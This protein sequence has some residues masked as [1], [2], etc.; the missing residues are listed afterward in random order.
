MRSTTWP[1]LGSERRAWTTPPGAV[2]LTRRER[3]DASQP[4]YEAALVPEIA[5][6]SPTLPTDV[7]AEAEDAVAEMARFDAGMGHEV[8]P[9]APVLL[10][11]E[12]IASSDIEH[13]TSSARNIALAEAT[14][15]GG[16]D[17]A[18]LVARNVRAMLR[19][20][21]ATTSPDV[22]GVLDLHAE[23]MRADP[24]HVAG[25]FR[26]EQVWIGGHSST[27]VGAHFVPPHHDRVAA[28]MDDL[29]SFVRRPDLPRLTQ[30]AV[31]HAQFETIHPFSD[32][33][34]RTGR[35]LMHVMLRDN[36]LV[37]HGV[38]P[39]SA[40]LLTDTAAYH[41]ALDAYRDGDP[42]TIVRLLTSSSLRAVA[43]ATRLVTEVRGIRQSW[44]ERVR[45]RRGTWTWLVVDLLLR[46]P[47]LTARTLKAELG[48]SPTHAPRV[49]EPLLQAGVVRRATH[50]ASRSTYWWSPEI[51][52]AVDDFAVRAGRR[53]L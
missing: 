17:N 25:A 53:R 22:S 11:G 49:M 20:I 15:G 52:D 24:H 43:N 50:Y 8:L 36:G 23:L 26:E 27:P 31:A 45:S 32:G 18:A 28:A 40:G 37:T 16:R 2:G 3:Q 42:V 10:R 51:L 12:A 34:G 21:D 44:D 29:S 13:I 33:N 35:A 1:S 41:Q 7:E 39:V 30:L 14:G 9:F 46:H 48:L 19:A 38:V 5:T 47:L 6:L 4:F